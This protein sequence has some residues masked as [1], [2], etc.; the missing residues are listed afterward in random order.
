MKREMAAVSTK[1]SL[2]GGGKN[3]F[4]EQ[5][6]RALAGCAI[7]LVVLALASVRAAEHKLP[8]DKNGTEE[9]AHKPY[10][11]V[12]TD[13]L[14][15]YEPDYE[16]FKGL[17]IADKI[18]Y[19]QQRKIEEAIVQMDYILYHFDKQ[20]QELLDVKVHWRE[21]LPEKLPEIISKEQAEAMVEGQV[22]YSG[23]FYICPNSAVFP[24][25]PTP[26]NPCWVVETL[27]NDRTDVVVIDAV[28]GKILGHGVPPP[29]TAFSC[30]GP[31]EENHETCSCSGA[32]G[33]WYENA[34]NWFNIMGYDTEGTIWPTKQ[35]VKSHIQSDDT[36][37]FYEL[38]HG[39]SYSFGAG[40]DYNS[41]YIDWTTVED[42]ET[43]I[44]NYEK[45]PF[46]F[47]GSCGGMCDTTDDTLSYEF[48]KGSNEYTVTVGYCGMGNSPCVDSC[49]YAGYTISWQDTLFNYINQG[50]T[51]KAA[52]NKA[53]AL[54]PGCGN[55]GCMRFAGDENF[56]LVPTIQRV[57]GAPSTPTLV[58]PKNG[59]TGISLTPTLQASAF[60]DSD[61]DL[62]TNSH[63]QVDDDSNFSSPEWDSGESYSASTQT[64]VPS[65]LLS[66]NTTY[67]WQVRYRN[68]IGIWSSWA[69]PWSFITW[70][71][72]PIYVDVNATGANNG[73]KWTDA[74]TDLQSALF[75]ARG[76]DEIWVAAGT[77]K[78]TTGT[79]RTISFVMKEN[80]AIYG[81]FTGTETSQDQRNWAL[82][83]T[84]LSGDI[85][86]QEDNSDNSY[87]VVV[88]ANDVTLDGFTITNG[89]ANGAAQA[90]KCGGG[91]Y[92][93]YSSPAVT[94]CT[95]SGNT[96]GSGGGMYNYYSSP[97]VTNCTFSGNSATY[98]GGIYSNYYGSPAVT[99][100][101]FSGNSAT[102]GGG[103]YSGSPTVTNCI[104]WADVPSEMYR[105]TP[106]VTYSDVQ[107]GWIGTGNI[108]ADPLFIRNPDPD[109][110]SGDYGDLRLQVGSPCVD[111]GDN[112]SVPPDY[113]DIDS[114]GNTTE[115]IPFD[116]AGRQR[117][118]D[119]NC[120]GQVVVDM[121]AYEFYLV[122][123]LNN[124]C[125]VNFIDFALF[126]LRWLETDC[127]ESNN[128]C[129]GAD[130]NKSGSV[131]L[132]DLGKFSDNWLEEL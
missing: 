5:V 86:T 13:L 120:D 17:E 112:N 20:T 61:G 12:S 26:L 121:G 33:Q 127:E 75:D 122:G 118:R 70:R 43:W 125:N 107:G 131:D 88:G 38:A 108:D 110:G 2:S 54:Y 4:G 24:I 50:W 23:L 105:S 109:P 47:I 85:G 117:I 6:R 100:C 77:Y 76:S 84:I 37:V 89:N 102:Y 30:T 55:Y 81:G 3:T 113:A 98:G 116:L 68:D 34:R 51:V 60:L 91:M 25:E 64:T 65:E 123:D 48:R 63:W 11:A 119:G 74:Y 90:D 15:Q 1:A 97:A 83:Q 80:V 66:Y 67:Y 52:F 42:I 31:W 124:N 94:N 92:N 96:A 71:G 19:F 28:K 56:G 106:I 111:A 16:N 114:D 78:P 22:Q 53:D 35:K 69:S 7:A 59:A 93:Y 10:A 44:A 103:I 79:D 36:A 57:R 40:Y 72:G 49:W 115:P 39:G 8:K 14:K 32:W 27:I 95:F 18:V 99:N 101:T 129:E 126:A 58:S 21:D 130:L 46:T 45:M 29:Y 128:W 132:Y 9:R 87:H 104:L 73:S 62:H 82:N 41:C